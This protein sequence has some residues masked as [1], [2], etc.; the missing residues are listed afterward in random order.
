MIEVIAF[1]DWAAVCDA[2]GQG[3]QSVILRKGGLAEGRE[4][5]QFKH[6]EFFLFPTG[7]HEQFEK[8]RPGLSGGLQ[9]AGDT[10]S[11]VVKIRDFF[12]LEWHATVTDWPAAR[13]LAPFHPYREEVVRERFDYDESP[14]LQVAFG[15]AFRL[16]K[17]WTLPHQASFGGCRS[18]ITL[19]APAPDPATMTPSLTNLQ[20]DTLA[21]QLDAWC[22]EFGIAVSRF[23]PQVHG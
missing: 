16:E 2:M 11:G 9:G 22:R 8:M 17:R 12:R 1:K 4:G 23:S 7:Y 21:E 20:H 6:P 14:G 15:R 13:A 19:P 18:W 5:F 3:R 10:G